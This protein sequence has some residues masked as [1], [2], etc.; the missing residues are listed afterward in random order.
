MPEALTPTLVLTVA[1]ILVIG[2]W[3][4]WY[5]KV[6]RRR[7]LLDRDWR[8][9]CARIP[10]AKIEG[11]VVTLYDVRHFNW[12]KSRDYDVV[13]AE[14]TY[15][16][17][18]LV[19]LWY[20]VDHFHPKFKGMAHVML[21]FEFKGDRFVTCSF[22]TRLVKGQRYHP[23]TGCWRGY[24]LLM[25][26]AGEEDLI[27]LRTN[28]RSHPVYLFPCVVPEGKGEAVFLRLCRRANELVNNPEWY[29]T[30]QTTCTTSLT[31]VVNQVTPGRVPFM[32]RSRTRRSWATTRSSRRATSPTRPS[33]TGTTWRVSARRFGARFPRLRPSSC[34]TRT[35][36]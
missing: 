22:E 2:T 14:E 17:E 3:L 34:R 12:R 33:P 21:S 28:V 31:D 29:H 1:G 20:V 8:T 7:P 23:W 11:H 18:E 5:L 19:G 35:A 10:T 9:E 16:T 13:Y 15:D 26:W 25:L 36:A 24:E 30:L 6:G 32:W 27:R 4:L